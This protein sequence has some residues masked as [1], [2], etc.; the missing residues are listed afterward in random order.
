MLDPK[1]PL[2]ETDEELEAML[3][4]MELMCTKHGWDNSDIYDKTE[5]GYIVYGNFVAESKTMN[6]YLDKRKTQTIT[7]K[8]NFESH[9]SD[10]TIE[11]SEQLNLDLNTQYLV[12]V[13]PIKDTHAT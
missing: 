10:Y 11:N 4:Y 8:F 2:K 6:E 1:T 9:T 5:S 13:I 3:F 7:T 12:T